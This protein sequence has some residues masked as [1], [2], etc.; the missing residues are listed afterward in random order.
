MLNRSYTPPVRKPYQKRKINFNLLW[1]AE[2]R[3][4]CREEQKIK[5][6]V[7]GMMT[8]TIGVPDG[9]A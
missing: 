5:M 7:L 4:E 3:L 8:S 2:S 1:E 9:N 6:D